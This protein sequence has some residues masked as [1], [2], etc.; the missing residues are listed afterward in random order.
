MAR[1]TRLTPDRQAAFAESVAQGNTNK[2]AAEAAGLSDRSVKRYLERGRN[3]QAVIDVHLDTITER[4]WAILDRWPDDRLDRYF[5]RLIAPAERPYWH[6]WLASTRARS[7]AESG[8]VENLTVCAQGYWWTETTVREV[9]VEGVVTPL[10]TTVRKFTRDWRASVVWLER[11]NPEEWGVRREPVEVV[12][13]GGGP[14]PVRP[15]EDAVAEALSLVDELEER[16][17]RAGET[18]DEAAG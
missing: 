2:T 3:A 1:A 5:A 7:T 16:R 11:R 13:Q 17:R 10:T 18:P 12:G 4:D 14:V 15:V 6:F 8:H 9:V